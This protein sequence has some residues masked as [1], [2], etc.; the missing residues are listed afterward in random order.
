MENI[1]Y[2]IVLRSKY[3]GEE[4]HLGSQYKTREEAQEYAE[5]S[6]CMRCNGYEIRIVHDEYQYFDRHRGFLDP[7]Y[8]RKLVE[9]GNENKFLKERRR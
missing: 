2:C 8:I 4:I 6:V 9:E 1:K 3:T 7:K 5:K